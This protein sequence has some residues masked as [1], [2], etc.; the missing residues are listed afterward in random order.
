[1][2]ILRNVTEAP[3]HV[4]GLPR[5]EAE[6]RAVEMLEKVGLG[7]KLDAYPAQLSGGQQQR[8]AIARALVMRPQVMLF[9]EVTSALDPELVGEVLAVLRKI[10]SEGDMTMIIVTTRWILPGKLPT[11]SLRGGVIV[12]EG[13]P[14]ASCN[15]PQRPEF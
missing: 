5:E 14:Q 3:L 1:M 13:P 4:L 9:D 11:D 15:P 12:E 8:V 10:A 2:K 7:D 6:A